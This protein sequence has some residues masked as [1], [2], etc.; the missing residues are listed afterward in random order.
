MA[1]PYKGPMSL[2]KITYALFEILEN[3]YHFILSWNLE[4][5]YK[6]LSCYFELKTSSLLLPFNKLK[7]LSDKIL[8]FFFPYTNL[9]KI[10]QLGGP[11]WDVKLG[12]RDSKTASFSAANSG[13]PPPSSSLHNL[14][15]RYRDLGLS[16][17]DL[18]ALSGMSP[19][20]R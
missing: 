13:L 4:I 19:T 14:I 1:L 2:K 11:N 10:V 12:R 6:Y 7:F 15:K 9:D 17:K 5:S 16:A 18:V 3:D 8:V 20:S